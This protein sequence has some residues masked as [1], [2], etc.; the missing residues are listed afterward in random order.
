MHFT[1]DYDITVNVV[2]LLKNNYDIT[3][4][5]VSLFKK[6]LCIII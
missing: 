3:F 2:S 6:Q 1:N 4:N 5:V